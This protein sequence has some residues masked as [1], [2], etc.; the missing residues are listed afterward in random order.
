MKFIETEWEG[1]RGSECG[2][3]DRVQKLLNIFYLNLKDSK[4]FKIYIIVFEKK[5]AFLDNLFYANSKEL[6][7]LLIFF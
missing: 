5:W 7:L 6:N 4:K 3:C 1:T 2:K